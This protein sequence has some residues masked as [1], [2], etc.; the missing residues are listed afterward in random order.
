MVCQSWDSVFVVCDGLVIAVAH[1]STCSCH[2]M[3]MLASDM[4]P[5]Q[6]K[7]CKSFPFILVACIAALAEL[8]PQPMNN[9]LAG[10]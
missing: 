7:G 4:S 8:Y 3:L 2:Q 6:H 9:Q 5:K 1:M 10:V